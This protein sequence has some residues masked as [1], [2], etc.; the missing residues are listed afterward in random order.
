M[1]C[2]YAWP[3]SYDHTGRRAFF[4]NQRGEV[5]EYANRRYYPFSGL[6]AGPP[7]D[8]AYSVVGDMGSPLRIGI[9]NGNGSI[10][11]PVP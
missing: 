2:C 7:F 8:D 6:S 3:V 4:I 11:W 1:W 10:W 9:L 5:L